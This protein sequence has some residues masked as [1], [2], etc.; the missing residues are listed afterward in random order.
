MKKLPITYEI[1]ELEY[2]KSLS[3]EVFGK[4]NKANPSISEIKSIFEC[5]VEDYFYNEV[6]VPP[7]SFIIHIDD[8]SYTAN[9]ETRSRP[10][11]VITSV[12][13]K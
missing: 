6:E 12:K 13:Q 5:V 9:V 11:F 7:E 8:K 4:F 10:E 3:V 1:P 2:S